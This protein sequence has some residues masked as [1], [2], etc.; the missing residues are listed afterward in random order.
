MR[1]HPTIL[2][3]TPD[4]TW[5]S[6]ISTTSDLQNKRVD[7]N[8]GETTGIPG[9]VDPVITPDGRFILVPQNTSGGMWFFSSSESQ[10]YQPLFYDEESRGVY[11][12]ATMP[13]NDI[14]LVFN[15]GK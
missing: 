13:E 1:F 4:G 2:K 9:F 11:Q 6:I 5:A 15:R 3:Y 14:M 8:S 10:D 12:S 7:L